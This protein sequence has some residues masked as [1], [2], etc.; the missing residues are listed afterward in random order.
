M[1]QI[2]NN[3]GL[4]EIIKLSQLIECN[5]V[6]KVYMYFWQIIQLAVGQNP[7]S[8]YNIEATSVLRY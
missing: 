4:L 2:L 6:K 8:E 3:A 7:G 1:K 5:G